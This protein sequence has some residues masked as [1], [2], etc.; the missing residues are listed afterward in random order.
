MTYA[1]DGVHL[2][3]KN[4]AT[5]CSGGAIVLGKKQMQG[6]HPVFLTKTQHARLL[7]HRAAGKEC[8]LKMSRGQLR[9]HMKH[10]GG[11]FTPYAYQIICSIAN[12]ISCSLLSLYDMLLGFWESAKKYLNKAIE[13]AKP[14]VGK[15]IRQGGEHLGDYVGKK[16]D[17]FLGNIGDKIGGPIGNLIKDLGKKGITKAT[18]HGK[19]KLDEHLKKHGAGLKVGKGPKDK[20]NYHPQR[21]PERK[22]FATFDEFYTANNKWIKEN[23]T[24]KKAS[25]DY[26]AAH[27]GGAHILGG[28]GLKVGKGPKDKWNYHPQRQPERKNFATFDEF[29]TAINKWIKE[30]ETYKKASQDYDAAHPGGAHILGGKGMGMSVLSKT[31]APLGEDPVLDGFRPTHRRTKHKLTQPHDESGNKKVRQIIKAVGQIKKVG[32]GLKF[33]HHGVK[34]HTIRKGQEGHELGKG[35]K[36]IIA[37]AKFAKLS[38]GVQ[39]KQHTPVY[40][41][42]LPTYV[43]QVT[44]QTPNGAT[45]EDLGLGSIGKGG[46]LKRRRTVGKGS[47]HGTIT[48]GR[49]L[50]L[51]NMTKLGKRAI[52]PA[53]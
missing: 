53:P 40:A 52:K 13:I 47:G 19:N 28:T 31:L 18:K 8:M 44:S 35:V 11:Q 23:E 50:N 21:Q 45:W 27:P 15:L 33:A 46:K 37:Q 14:H 43:G 30:N 17:E 3:H 29:Y 12:C 10:G 48:M 41:H 39:K 25:Q 9:H 24:Y 51:K 26:D 7:K 38:P 2:T 32:D 49:G 6:E 36:E 5:L 4:L 20:W 34:F 1:T 42:V 16:G 22:N